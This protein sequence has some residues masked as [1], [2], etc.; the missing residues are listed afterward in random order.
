[1]SVVEQRCEYLGV[2]V[3]FW[4]FCDC[5]YLFF[6]FPCAFLGFCD[7]FWGFVIVFVCFFEIFFLRLD[8]FKYSQIGVPF[9]LYVVM[10]PTVSSLFL[11]SVSNWLCLIDF[12]FF[13]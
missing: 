3:L 9:G 8:C 12:L 7:C 10:R 11:L 4:G 6:G 2:F 13:L 5:F 1:M